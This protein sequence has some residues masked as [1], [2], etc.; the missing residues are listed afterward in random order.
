MTN[1]TKKSVL[2]IDNGLFLHFAETLTEFFGTVYYWSPWVGAFPKSNSIIVGD[3]VPGITRIRSIWEVADEVDLFVFLDIGFGQ[4]Q[5]YLA[6]K[7]KRVWGSRMGEELELDRIWAKQKAIELGISIGPYTVVRGIDNLR[8]YLRDNPDQYVK[9][10]TLRGDAETFYSQDYDLVEPRIDQLEWVLGIK[11]HWTEFIVE[12]A[13]HDA[14]EVG[15]DGFTIDGSYA[16]K[17]LYGIEVKDK[18][19][20][21]KVIPYDLLPPPL[22]DVNSKLS[23]YFMECKYRGIFSSEVRVS[24]KDAYLIDP[25]CRLPSPPGELYGSIID[26]W[27]DIIWEG[28]EGELIEPDFVAKFGACIVL[29]SQWALTNWQAVSYPNSVADFVKMKNYTVLDG[30]RYVIPQTV[31]PLDAI[32]V[33]IGLGNTAKEAIM[34]A[35]RNAEQV[36]G[37]GIEYAH[38]VANDALEQMDALNDG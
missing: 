37:L 33:V 35:E 17:S 36:E 5:E 24:G 34:K 23:P 38:G 9:V 13:I 3:G 18:A 20:L 10:S 7:G 16:Q 19:Y 26:N 22:I 4:L 27:S 8:D 30:K 25:C 21:G 28:A 11:K 15:Y 6:S 1:Y 31:C 29:C 12:K 14:I 32:G 2:C